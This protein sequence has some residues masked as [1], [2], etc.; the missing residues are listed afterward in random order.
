M[1]I[2]LDYFLEIGNKLT[3]SL[4][5]QMFGKPCFKL[6]GKAYICFFQ[7]DM[8]FKLT[9]DVREEALELEDSQQFDPSGKKRP[10]KE[11]TQVPYRYKDK[12]EKYAKEALAYVKATQ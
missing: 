6:S 12:W 4:P 10:M 11:W 2:E 5:G 9:G 3:D 8:V 1:S 7:N